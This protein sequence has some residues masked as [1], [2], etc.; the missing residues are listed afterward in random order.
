[1][2]AVGLDE[3]HTGLLWAMLRKYKDLQEKTGLKVLK[4]EA[5]LLEDEFLGFVDVV[6]EEPDGEG[7]WIVD[8]KTAGR[9]APDLA[10]RLPMDRQLNLYRLRAGS[11]GNPETFL[12]CRYRVVTKSTAKRKSSESLK[13]YSD[14]LYRS[15]SAV[16]FI[17]PRDVMKPEVIDE[18]FR[19]LRKRQ[20]QLV[21]KTRKPVKNFSYCFSYF[22]PCEYYSRCHGAT[23]TSTPRVEEVSV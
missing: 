12:G 5:E 21:R 18:N 17:I 14:R 1:M 16:D 23:F 20:S 8:V 15:I 10:A 19:Q 2:V 7:W 22:R 6:M 9:L 4:C 11:L 13:D 3:A